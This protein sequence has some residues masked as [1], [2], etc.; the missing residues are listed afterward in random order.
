MKKSWRLLEKIISG[1]KTIESRWYKAKYPP[2]GKI[3]AGDT[4]WFKDSGCPVTAKA[5]VAKVKEF[6]NLTK[7]K[8]FNILKQY[9][10]SDGIEKK[11]IPKFYELFKGKK[12]CILIFLRNPAKIKPFQIDKKGY[13]SMASWICINKIEKIK[14]KTGP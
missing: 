12:Y 8:V 6:S 7:Q 3:R 10:K 4:V 14:R 2:L 9:G 5:D 1:E 11:D 13:G